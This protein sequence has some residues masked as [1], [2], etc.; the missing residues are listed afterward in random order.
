MHEADGKEGLWAQSPSGEKWKSYGDGRLPD[1]TTDA[2]TTAL[3]QCQKA[4][5]V[6]IKEVHD[7]YTSKQAI[8][9]TQY[10]AWQHAPILETISTQPENHK[11]LLDIKDDTIYYRTGGIASTK[12]NEIKSVIDWGKFYVENFGLVEG[13]VLLWLKQQAPW[14]VGQGVKLE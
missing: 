12:Y 13:Q 4:L 7:A 9:E 11:P 6:S 8:P 10:G 5:E 14:L 3:K 2:T 1:H